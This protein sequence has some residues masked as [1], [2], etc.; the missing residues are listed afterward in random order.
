[1]RFDDDAIDPRIFPRRGQAPRLAEPARGPSVSD[2]RNNYA[3]EVSQ[4]SATLQQQG[5]QLSQAAAEI[6]RLTQA[7]E[8]E[9]AAHAATRVR[10]AAVRPVIL[11]APSTPKRE[12]KGDVEDAE[13]VESSPGASESTEEPEGEKKAE[14]WWGAGDDDEDDDGADE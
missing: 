13:I 8:R 12:S 1:M 4:L 14:P 10:L 5:R 2:I 11:A 6:R 9:Q 7:L 3:R